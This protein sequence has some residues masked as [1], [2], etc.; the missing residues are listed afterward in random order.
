VREDRWQPRNFFQDNFG[1]VCR[2][3]ERQAAFQ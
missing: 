2:A 3:A 1:P